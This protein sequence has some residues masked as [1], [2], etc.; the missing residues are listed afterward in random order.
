[1]TDS[2]DGFDDDLCDHDDYDTDLLSGRC[3]C[4][5][6]G[7]T[8]YATGEE[9]DRELRFQSEYHEAMEREDRR[10][11]WSDLFYNVRHPLQ[12]IHWQVQKRGWLSGRSAPSDD[13]VPF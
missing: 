11:W 12:A 9:I 7:E 13:D 6:C 2:D 5:R 10:Q 3:Q 8:W 4:W 1:M